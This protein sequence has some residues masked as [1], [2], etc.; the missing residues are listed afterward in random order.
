VKSLH[1]RLTAWLVIGSGLLLV[2]GCLVLNS[3]ITARLQSDLDAELITKATALSTLTEQEDG[4]VWLELTE[5]GMPEFNA[6]AG[7]KAGKAGAAPEY[8]QI[9]RTDGS[10]VAR[11]LSLAGRDLPLRPQPAS[12]PLFLDLKLP[13]GRPGRLVEFSFQP[14]HEEDEPYAQTRRDTGPLEVTSVTLALASGRQELDAFLA[15]L[16]GVLIAFVL[17]LLA[18][19]FVLVRLSMKV[20]LAPLEDLGARLT[21]WQ[22]ESLGEELDLAGAPAELA[23]VIFRLNDLLKRLQES[24]G[25]ERM[26]SANLAHELRTPLAEL[27]SMVEVALKWPPGQAATASVLAEVRTI[28]LQMERIV[29]NLLVL[30][31]CDGGLQKVLPS[32]VPVAD[33]IE[34]CWGNVAAEAERRGVVLRSTVPEDLRIHTDEDKLAL[35]LSNLLSNAVSYGEPSE[36]VTCSAAVVSGEIALRVSNRTAAL[37]PDDLPRMFDRFWR[38]DSARSDGEHA[39]LGLS[40]VRALSTL[41]GFTVTAELERGAVLHLTLTGRVA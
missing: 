2:L 37:H 5:G 14:R 10:V 35:I 11:S 1:G 13:D 16:R 41:L 8:F 33:L 9:W 38:K 12:R 31:R 21:V 15:S 34:R 6:P 24:F 27:R 19:I 29:T 23:P 25:R 17:A 22:V 3:L 7:G 36:P 32:E 30:A 26:F 20:S 40:L 28:G 18:G 39:G 4:A